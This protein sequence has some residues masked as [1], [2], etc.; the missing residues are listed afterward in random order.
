VLALALLVRLAHLAFVAQSPM[1]SYHHIFLES[2]MHIFDRWAH[3]ILDGDVLGRQPYHFLA[4]WQLA[5][6]PAE[7]WLRWYGEPLVFHKA[8]FY[9][10]LIALLFRVFGDSMLPLAFLQIL[11]STAAV[12]LLYRVTERLLGTTVGL[13][14]ATI[15]AIYA[16]A[17][18]YDVIMLR[19]PWIVLT[20]LFVTWRL[21][22]LR[23]LPSFGNA[24]L[25]GSALGLALLVNEGFVPA[26]PLAALLVALW[27]RQIR[28]LAVLLSGLA[29]GTALAVV[30]VLVRN[31]VVGAPV[32][33]WAVLGSAAYA[34]C[35]TAGTSPYFFEAHPS[36]YQPV[37]E[38]SGGAL[39]K[40]VL[41]CLRSFA[42]PG[43]VFL[44]YL[45]RV[46]GI[47]IP[48]E[49]PDNAN[50]YY[51][52]LKSPL[53]AVLPGWGILFPLAVVGLAL[54]VRRLRDLAP[55]LPA[56]LTLLLTIVLTVPMSRYRATAAVYLM[57][58][59]G[60]TIVRAAEWAR[61]RKALRLAATAIAAAAVGLGTVAL[62]AKLVFAGQPKGLYLYRAAEFELGARYFE[63]QGRLSD[64][65]GEALA[66]ARLNPDRRLK[67]SALVL[68]GKLEARQGHATAA[69][70]ALAGAAIFGARDPGTLLDVADAQA[71]L[72]HDRARALETYRLAAEQAAGGP[73]QHTIDERLRSLGAEADAKQR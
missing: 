41:L 28:R 61:G 55:L 8:P 58:L 67:A 31:Y 16:P 39:A 19:G 72:L 17:I 15:L 37:L 25:L 30:P 3:K 42:G 71:T 69:R 33:E 70:E 49:N 51:A 60:L 23:S 52:A 10:Y 68:V 54:A 18:H 45:R 50:F 73:L 40:T 35:N 9:A 62:Q 64:A 2:D 66:F 26:L 22:K 5:Q 36:E 13:T 47:A 20:S 53:L 34:V 32:L 24:V 57:P 12:A 11:A 63:T 1:P 21:V 14:S 46:V 7:K 27:F 48:F 43:D 65:T 59:A 38:A 6:A 29:L 56:A 44:F 4:Q